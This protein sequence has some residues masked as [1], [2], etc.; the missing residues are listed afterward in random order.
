MAVFVLRNDIYLL[1]AKWTNKPTEKSDLVV[2]NEKVSSNRDL[3]EVYL[4]V[5]LVIAVMQLKRFVMVEKLR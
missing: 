2:F 5:L 4:S 3:Q 1:E